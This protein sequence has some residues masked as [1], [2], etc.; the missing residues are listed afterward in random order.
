MAIVR[1]DP[2]A[3]TPRWGNWPFDDDEWQG[4]MAS[5]TGDSLEMY[6]EGDSI[7]VKAN[8]AGV[9]P[10]EVDVQFKDGRL[11]IRAQASEEKKEGKKFYRKAVRAY[12]YTVDVPYADERH[13]P[14]AD[15]EKGILTLTFKRAAEAK[16][17]KIAV[18]AK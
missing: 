11:W 7:I 8:V 5:S 17:K 15:I 4:L 12:S 14:T 13:E 2:F 9:K 1:W 3:L 10:E 16:P 6:E 18:K